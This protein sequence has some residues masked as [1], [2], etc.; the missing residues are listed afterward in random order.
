MKILVTGGT[1][2][3]GTR[4]VDKL[5]EL[6]HDVVILDNKEGKINKKS[7]YVKGDIGKKIDIEKA[8]KDCRVVF[9]LSPLIHSIATNKK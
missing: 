6:G 3:I 1:G 7:K 4:L 8:I 5:I 2:F 9:S